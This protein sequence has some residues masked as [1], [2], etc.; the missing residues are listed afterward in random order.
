MSG[1]K[2][3]N[4]ERM[5]KILHGDGRVACSPEEELQAINYAILRSL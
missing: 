1:I 3:Y 4:E 5:E 2:A